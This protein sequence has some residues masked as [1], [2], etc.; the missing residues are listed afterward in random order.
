M[1]LPSTTLLTLVTASVRRRSCWSVST[2]RGTMLIDCGE[3][4]TGVS[5]RVAVAERVAR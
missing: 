5:V 2:A 4:R 3:S 1:V